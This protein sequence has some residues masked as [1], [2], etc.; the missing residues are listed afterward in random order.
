[1]A[2][3]VGFSCNFYVLIGLSFYLPLYSQSVLGVN[4]LRSGVYLVPLIVSSSLAAAGAGIFSQQTGKYLP[5]MY[6]SQVVLTLGVGL[7]INLRFEESLAKLFIFEIVA[8]IGIGMNIE[9]PVLAAT[10]ASTVLD[11]AA[12]NASMSF[13]RSIATAIAIVLGGVIFQSRM[14]AANQDLADQ[15]GTQFALSFNGDHATAN[16]ELIRSLPAD[17]RVT[18]RRVHFEAL[19]AGWIM[20]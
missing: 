14:N 15:I 10:A 17:Q 2:A 1:M 16:V 4:A 9:P 19:R 18:I 6:L 5:V 11:T 20:V 8:G 13:F 3:Y 7:F 12:I